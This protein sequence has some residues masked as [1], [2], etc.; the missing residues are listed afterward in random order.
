MEG[1]LTRHWPT[2][3]GALDALWQVGRPPGLRLTGPMAHPGMTSLCCTQSQLSPQCFL[4]REGR[5]PEWKGIV[6]GRG[7]SQ[8]LGNAGRSGRRVIW[9]VS[10]HGGRGRPRCRET[11]LLRN[12]V[13]GTGLTRHV[14]T[15]QSAPGFLRGQAGTRWG[16]DRG[17]GCQET[18]G[19]ELLGSGSPLEEQLERLKTNGKQE[20]SSGCFPPAVTA[21][22]T[23]SLKWAQ[24]EQSF[25]QLS[26]FRK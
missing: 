2:S 24:K 8:E 3:Q 14:K 22:V 13:A 26:P 21:L 18:W 10:S 25:R 11:E 16:G 23:L 20:L 4:P 1:P 15:R 7:Q 17:W 9:P 5:G 19:G 6:S 12:R